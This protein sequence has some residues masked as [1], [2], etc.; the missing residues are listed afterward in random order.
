[1][2]LTC[3]EPE[4]PSLDLVKTLR[5]LA[6]YT[7]SHRC[8]SVRNGEERPTHPQADPLQVANVSK[9][10]DQLEARS[11]TTSIVAVGVASATKRVMSTSKEVKAT[12]DSHEAAMRDWSRSVRSYEGKRSHPCVQRF[13]DRSQSTVH[14]QTCEDRLKTLRAKAERGIRQFWD[15]RQ[16]WEEQSTRSNFQCPVNGLEVQSYISD[17]DVPDLSDLP[18]LSGYDL[19]SL[20]RK[21]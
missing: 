1:M 14:R 2:T 4:L 15:L 11:L 21:L 19:V 6:V 17:G 5:K 13:S 10:I 7:L 3:F 9:A 8:I 12:L 18:D 16:F 20:R